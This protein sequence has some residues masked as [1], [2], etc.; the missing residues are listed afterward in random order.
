MKKT[1]CCRARGCD[2]R[3]FAGDR[4]P[5]QAHDGIGAGI[6]A[7]LIGGAIIGGAIAAS[8]PAL[9]R[10]GVCGRSRPAPASLLLAAPALLGR[11]RLELSAG[12]G[13]LLI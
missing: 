9:R 6:A 3:R 11:L 10:P 12:P 4:T 5:A 2:D 8:R 7:G 13:L 1:Y